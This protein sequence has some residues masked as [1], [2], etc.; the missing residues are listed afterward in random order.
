MVFIAA[1]YDSIECDR[2]G[3]HAFFIEAYDSAAPVFDYPVVVVC[4]M[5]A[6]EEHRLL[7]ALGDSHHT[8]AIDHHLSADKAASYWDRQQKCLNVGTNLNAIAVAIQDGTDGTEEN[9]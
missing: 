7:Q 5:C 2:C 8:T 3:E 4:F 9:A 1:K 6:T